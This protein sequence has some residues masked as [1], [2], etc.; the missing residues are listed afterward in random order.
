M[1]LATQLDEKNGRPVILINKFDVKP[2][3]VDEFLAA[4][5]ADATYFKQKP[6]FISTQLHRGIGGSCAFINYT[7]W[8]SVEHYKRSTGDHAFGLSLRR[9]QTLP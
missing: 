1:T 3:D 9:Y 2:N 7:E 5:E 8:K 6:G 4:W